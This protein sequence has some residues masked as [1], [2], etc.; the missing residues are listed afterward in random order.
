ML[1]MCMCFF[2]SCESDE[3]ITKK[4]E[5][6]IEDADYVGAQDLLDEHTDLKEHKKLSDIVKYETII[7]HCCQVLSQYLKSPDSLYLK[8]VEFYYAD[9]YEP[10][11]SDVKFVPKEN[12]IVVIKYTAQN[13]FGGNVEDDMI[14]FGNIEYDDE[15]MCYYTVIDEY[16]EYM[17]D[18][19]WYES[20]KEYVP[21]YWSD[22]E[23]LELLGKF[24][25]SQVDLYRVMRVF[26]EYKSPKIDVNRYLRP[27]EK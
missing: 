8:N 23:R 14:Y 6:L 25:T 17:S 19:Y 26:K 9:K 21:S 18:T 11:D 13:G 22:K 7:I 4:I 20:V 5:T 15:N 16:Y 27:N 2:V 10:E 12:P 3:E 1:S 24:D